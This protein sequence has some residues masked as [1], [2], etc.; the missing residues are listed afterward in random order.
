MMRARVRRQLLAAAATMALVATGATAAAERG[1]ALFAEHCA[2]C[3][4]A[5]GAGVPGFGPPLAGPVAVRMKTPGGREYVAAVVVHGISGVFES[6]GQR[7]FGAMTP[8][9]ALPDDDLAA[10]LNHVLG[11]LNAGALP[12]EFPSYTAAS[13][14]AARKVARTPAELHQTKAAL[15]RAAR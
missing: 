5:A 6:G 2:I 4:D 15:E 13:I 9:P 14:A 11:T 12:T 7:Q 1:A 10:I 8:A 3:H